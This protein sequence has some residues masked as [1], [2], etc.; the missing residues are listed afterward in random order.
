MSTNPPVIDTTSF[1][2]LKGPLTD[3]GQLNQL[4]QILRTV[5]NAIA[6]LSGNRGS[7]AYGSDINLNGNKCVDSADPTD[8]QDLVTLSYLK[9]NYG[10]AQVRQDLVTTQ[11][12]SLPLAPIVSSGGGSSGGGGATVGTHATRLATAPTSL[13]VGTQFFETDRTSM[14]AVVAVSGVNV[15]L[16]TGG[17]Y[18]AVVANLP[19]DLTLNDAGFGFYATD[20]FTVYIWTGAGFVTVGGAVQIGTF[21]LSGLLVKYNSILT[22]G[23]GIPIIVASQRLTGQTAAIASIAPYTVGASDSSFIVQANVN[24][25]AST[26][27]NFNIQVAYTDETNTARVLTL[28][29]TQLGGVPITNLTNVTGVSPYSGGAFRI[30]CKS[31][32][33]ITPQATGTFTTVTYNLEVTIL[34]VA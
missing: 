31:G 1:S 34:Q 32:T 13:P 2:Q 3:P 9:D 4:N 7:I 15:W 30:R 19:G 24:I 16:W 26:T 18:R 25:T 5:Q 14:Y 28:P 21:S 22:A 20:N 8:D 10:T 23:L 6:A 17:I 12:G 11:E 29:F 33:T 27:H